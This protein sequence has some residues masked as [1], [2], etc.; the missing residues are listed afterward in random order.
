MIDIKDKAA[1]DI[2]DRAANADIIGDVAANKI[3]GRGVE[4]RGCTSTGMRMRT[5]RLGLGTRGFG[6]GTRNR[7]C[8]RT[9]TS[10]RSTGGRSNRRSGNVVVVAVCGS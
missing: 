6:V 5:R 8:I 10:S 3:D 9:R 2:E 4:T 1:I 7:T